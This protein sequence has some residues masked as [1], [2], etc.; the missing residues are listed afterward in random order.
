MPAY[1]MFSFPCYLI[2]FAI[3]T[4][5]FYAL[6]ISVLKT[7]N[8]SLDFLGATQGRGNRCVYLTNFNVT[9]A[10]LFILYISTNIC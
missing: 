2:H 7:V 4:Y 1:C 6:E 9:A 8:I 5:Y 3:S 10:M